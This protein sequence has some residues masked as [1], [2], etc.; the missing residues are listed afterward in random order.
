MSLTPGRGRSLEDLW[1]FNR[2]ELA[3][4]VRRSKIPV[5]SAVGHEIDVTISDLVADF[6]AP[7]PSAAA[8]LL[9]KEKDA[10]SERLNGLRK[11]LTAGVGKHLNTMARDLE[12]LSRSLKG[13]GKRLEENWQRLDELHARLIRRTAF[14]LRLRRER[15]LSEWQG[16]KR[17]S[18]LTG[19]TL[20]GQRLGFQRASLHRSMAQRIAVSRRSLSLMEKRLHDLS[21][22]SILGRGYSITFTLPEKTVLRDAEG[23]RKGERVRV[24]LARG[25][26]DC[27]VDRTG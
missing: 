8:E 13:P 21:P 24:M 15:L 25:E 3:H 16:L 1:A 10:L 27:T 6:R 4:A 17:R 11:R 12:R 9:V 19:I 22:L 2:E 7:T 5:V 18:P 26:L 14:D 20:M 23:T